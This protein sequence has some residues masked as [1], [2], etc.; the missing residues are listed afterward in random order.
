ITGGTGALGSHVARWAARQGAAHLVLT[1]RR[2]TEA[3]QAADLRDELT[4]LG[5]RVTIAACDVAEREQLAAVL[6]TLDDTEPLTAVVHAA[7]V[8][9][10]EVPT[11]EMSTSDL[12]RIIRVKTEGARNLDALTADHDLDA[13]VLFSS[14]AGTWGDAGKAGYAAANA[15]LDAFA[16]ARRARGA[17]ATSVAWGAWDGGGMV[18]GDVADL[19]TR[20]GMRLMRPEAA[21]RALALAVGNGDTAVAIASIDL[22]RFLPLYTMTRDRRLVAELTAA[23]PLSPQ[24]ELGAAPG[25]ERTDAL[26]DRLAGLSAEERETTLVDVVRREAAAV[27]KAGRP[28]EIRPRRAFKELGFDSLTALEFRNRLNTATGLRLPATLVFDYPTPASLARHLRDELSGGT[29]DVLAELDRLEA[30]LSALPDEEWA[31]LDVAARLR[32][33]LRRAD[34]TAESA[35]PRED[36]AAATNDEIFDLIDRELGIR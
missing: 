8:T 26:A 36:L 5:A 13:F 21:V 24:G 19:L 30:G 2:G 28:E 18:E 32:A 35:D 9:Q 15:Y 4:A 7:G 17:V 31:R 22:A 23:Q 12:A 34:Q 10:P 25:R 3:P 33:L 1:S 6:A 20:R 27:L 29:N 16:Q 14:G 11:G